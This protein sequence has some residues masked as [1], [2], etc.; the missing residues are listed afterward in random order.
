MSRIPG[1]GGNAAGN[2]AD[3]IQPNVLNSPSGPAGTSH[4]R[5]GRAAH[6]RL[7]VMLVDRLSLDAGSSVPTVLSGVAARHDQHVRSGPG[8]PGLGACDSA[9]PPPRSRGGYPVYVGS[10]RLRGACHEGQHGSKGAPMRE[11]RAQGARAARM[12]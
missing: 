3:P 12:R 10:P 1:L 11:A 4:P 8:L 7:L 9:R 5:L 6:G 2:G